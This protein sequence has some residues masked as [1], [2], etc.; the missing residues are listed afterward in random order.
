MENEINYEENKDNI[1]GEYDEFLNDFL[2]Q[3]CVENNANENNNEVRYEYDNNINE[4]KLSSDGGLSNEQLN[5]IEES[6]YKLETKMNVFENRLNDIE[7]NIINLIK[8]EF[9][10]V[11]GNLSNKK[12]KKL[13]NPEHI[14]EA[15]NSKGNP[16]EAFKCKQSKV[17]CHAHYQ[18]ALEKFNP[19]AIKKP[20]LYRKRK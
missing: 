2:P 10:Y 20:H 17:L 9:T 15:L 1:F 7:L 3:L 11:R 18:L 6:V 19:K 8:K 14:C 16:C 4:E 12:F 5:T 13:K